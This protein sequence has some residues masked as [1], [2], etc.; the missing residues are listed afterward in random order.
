MLP[1]APY[2]ATGTLPTKAFMRWG[3][4]GPPDAPPQKTK[5]G[6]KISRHGIKSEP[7]C[8]LK[9][10]ENSV[11]MPPIDIATGRNAMVAVSIQGTHIVYHRA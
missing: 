1:R 4:D 8:S 2:D 10:F 6:V 9:C 11:A 5:R 7:A 3:R